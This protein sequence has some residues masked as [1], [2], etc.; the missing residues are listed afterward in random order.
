MSASAFQFNAANPLVAQPAGAGE[1]MIFR[2]DNAADTGNL[3]LTGLVAAVSTTDTL[4]LTGKRE[5][6]TTSTFTSLTI[7]KLSAAQTGAVSVYGQGTAAT[8][9]LRVDSLPAN[10][11]T[12]LIGL[13]GFLQTYT[14]K[15]TLTG[16]A[17]EI[18]IAAS[19]NAQATN[20]YEAIN[21]GAN[22]GTDYGTGTVA[23]AYAIATAPVGAVIGLTDRLKIVRLLAWSTTQGTGA[24]ISIRPLIGGVTGTLLATLSA[25]VTTSYNSFTLATEDTATAT[26]PAKFTGSSD[27]LSIGG[28]VTTLRFQSQTPNVSAVTISYQTSTDGTH[29]MDGVTA[30]ANMDGTYVPPVPLFVKPSEQNI[31]YIRL[32]VNTNANTASLEFDARAIY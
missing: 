32:N 28:R 20:I 21:A 15:T 1:K 22:A 24:T 30:V 14:F 6:A 17:N 2:S 29:W 12:L 26:L 13:T 7:A 5:K 18:K 25:G 9:D 27:A 16:A 10:N 4:A 3:S 11:D 8:G 23:N 31:E 19:V